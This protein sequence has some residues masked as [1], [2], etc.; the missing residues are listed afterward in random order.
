M[1]GHVKSTPEAGSKPKT[2]P[3]DPN[4][5]PADADLYDDGD[6]ATPKRDFDEEDL[7][8]AEDKRI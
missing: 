2:G 7:K 8:D 1:T 5:K 6:F 3:Q 4:K